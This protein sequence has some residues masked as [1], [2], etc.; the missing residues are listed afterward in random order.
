MQSDHEDSVIDAILT[1]AIAPALVDDMDGITPTAEDW[2]CAIA[3]YVLGLLR[4]DTSWH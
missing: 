3:A 1:S 4:H 2:R